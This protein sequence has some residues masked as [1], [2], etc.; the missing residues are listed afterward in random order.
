VLYLCGVQLVVGSGVLTALNLK[1]GCHVDVSQD[2]LVEDIHHMLLFAHGGNG[3]NF[4][5]FV[6]LCY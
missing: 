3:A 6:Y 4:W 1:G 5:Q 2:L